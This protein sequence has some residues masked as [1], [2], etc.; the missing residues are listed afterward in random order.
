MG[1]RDVTITKLYHTGKPVLSYL[2]EVVYRDEEVVV[3]R[4]LWTDSPLD[5]DGFCLQPGDIFMEFYYPREPFDIFQIHDIAGR[6][7]GW[8]CNIT[9]PA[10]ITD[11]EI[12]WHDLVLDL[13]VL[14]DGRQM[15]R[16]VEEFE[17]LHPSADLRARVAA[18]MERLQ[19]WVK[20]GH[21]PFAWTQQPLD[22]RRLLHGP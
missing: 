7:K 12:H 15:I 10:E 14:S 17:A 19:R 3:A 8:Y 16:D 2:G 13:L 1:A 21:A 22:G 5:L 9:E 20:E 18:A 11:G 4:C 6:L